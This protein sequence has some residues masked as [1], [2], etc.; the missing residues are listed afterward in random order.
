MP[1]FLFLT[2]GNAAGAEAALQLLR[3]LLLMLVFLPFDLAPLLFLLWLLLVYTCFGVS[4]LMCSD[5]THGGT[6]PTAQD[7]S[8]QPSL[9]HYVV[10]R[11]GIP[12]IQLGGA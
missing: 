4:L 2:A 5:A 8:E 1:F 3:Q 9:K 11:K 10:S 12:L 6:S 7:W